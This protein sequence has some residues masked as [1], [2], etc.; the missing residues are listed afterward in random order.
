MLIKIASQVQKLKIVKICLLIYLGTLIDRF[1]KFVDL[2][3]I[4]SLNKIL[5][6]I[7]NYI[8]KKIIK[9]ETG[10]LDVNF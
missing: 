8:F 10:I 1:P 2:K 3:K 9:F 6:I 4:K 5:T 7:K